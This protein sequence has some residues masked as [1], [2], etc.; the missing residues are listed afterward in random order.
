LGLEIGD[1]LEL[2]CWDL[3]ISTPPDQFAGP[4]RLDDEQRVAMKELASYLNDHLAGSVAAIELLDHLTK[5]HE[6]KPLAKLF[7][8]LRDDISADQDVLRKLLRKFKANESAIRKAGGWLAEKF[9]RA[10][11]QAAGDKFG[12]MGLVQALEVLVLGITGKQLLWRA[13]NA[14]LG[15]SPL[16]RGVDLGRLEERA[17]EQ[18][19]R[20]EA[21]RLE[22]AREVFLRG[23]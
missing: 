17:I 23:E 19:E 10:K 12:E 7:K 20:I 15:P 22:A 14:A 4:N 9:G 1:S 5:T 8:D 16:L 3:K 13:L 21:K 11:I 18:I 2:G 6:N